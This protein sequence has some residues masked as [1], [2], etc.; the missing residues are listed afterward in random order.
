MIPSRLV[1][2][3][4]PAYNVEKYI[5]EAIE[6]LLIQTYNNLEIIIV[7]DC[8]DDKTVNIIKKFASKDKRIRLYKNKKNRK[9]T[10]SLNKGL[11]YATGNFIARM[12]A[13]DI[14]SS[15]RIEQQMDFLEKNKHIG[16]VGTQQLNIDSDGSVLGKSKKVINRDL[17]KK[18]LLLASPIPHPT[19]LVRKSVFEKV[20]GYHTNSPAQ[21]YDFLLRM[22][23]LDLQFRNINIYGN[24]CRINRA[25]NTSSTSELERRKAVNYMINCYRE[26]KKLNIDLHT[27]ERLSKYLDS[28]KLMKIIHQKSQNFFENG[29]IKIKNK[30]KVSGFLKI[31]C[32]ALMSPYQMQ[33]FVRWFRLKIIISYYSEK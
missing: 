24:K 12:D 6:S 14:A 17:L 29:V 20:G 8:S 33:F 22:D 9:I 3:I 1:S 32:S 10:Y 13:D 7:D 4:M 21:D 26:R 2:V 31:I 11:K 30:S 23:T 25:G 16:L 28:T 18:T 19:W 27:D 5:N 15:N